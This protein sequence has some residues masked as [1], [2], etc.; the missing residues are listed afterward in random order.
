MKSAEGTVDYAHGHRRPFSTVVGGGKKPDLEPSRGGL[1]D[2]FWEKLSNHYVNLRM[3]IS[4]DKIQG[5]EQ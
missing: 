2:D 1:R 5:E 3:F 4:S